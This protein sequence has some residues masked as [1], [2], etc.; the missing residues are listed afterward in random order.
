MVVAYTLI[1]NAYDSDSAAD[2]NAQVCPLAYVATVGTSIVGVLWYTL[3]A[4]SQSGKAAYTGKC[5]VI[6]VAREWQRSGVGRA[7]WRTLRQAHPRHRFVIVADGPRA[8]R[9]WK[10]MDCHSDSEADEPLRKRGYP[11]EQLRSRPLRP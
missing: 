10:G 1:R 6:A 7:L 5:E 11:G 2:F 8:Y 4:A 9:F 3:D